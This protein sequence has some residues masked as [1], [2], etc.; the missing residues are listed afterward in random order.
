MMKQ[1]RVVVVSIL[2]QIKAK[3]LNAGDGVR[4]LYDYKNM[5]TSAQKRDWRNEA[6]QKARVM[7]NGVEKLINDLLIYMRSLDSM[8][9]YPMV[10]NETKCVNRDEVL[11]EL[12]KQ[13]KEKDHE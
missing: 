2:E 7:A 1:A 6:G 4:L 12:M 3:D 10:V 5:R 11:D 13:I 8:T 9:Y